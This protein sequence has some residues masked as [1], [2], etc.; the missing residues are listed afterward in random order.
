MTNSVELFAG[1]G[2]LALGLERAGAHHLALYEWDRHSC[3]NL[4]A[5]FGGGSARPEIVCADVRDTDFTAYEGRAD[6]LAGGPPC[7]PFSV[8]GKGMAYNDS[9]DMF[10]EAV[11]ALRE[12]RPKAFVIE[13]VKGL[14]R[15]SFSTYFNYIILQLQHPEVAKKA[16]Q[17]WEEHLAALEKHHTATRR[18]KGL[19]YNV[20]FRL[21]DAADYGVPQRRGR[22]VIVG[23]RSDIDAGWTFPEPTHSEAALLY[24]K[25]VSFTYWDEHNLPHPDAI[26]LSDRQISAVRD[27]CESFLGPKRWRTVR[28]AIGNLPAPAD[29]ECAGVAN[30][31]L[32]HGAREYPG[33]TGSSLDQPSKTIKA[34]A[35]GVPGGENMVRLDDGSLR[36]YTVRESARIQT[37]PDE[38]VFTSPW[39]ESMRQIGNAVPVALAEAIGASVMG[40]LNSNK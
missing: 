11:R 20:T 14:L 15:K 17:T 18:C 38:F 29:A 9:R 10:P 40:K 5:N 19:E 34:G 1:T 39:S 6:L 31:V 27:A 12:I 28:D 2:G 13:N 25:W 4:A 32:R 33:H 26:P 7:Q 30:H 3:A 16:A 37:F 24:A 36:Y 8:G 21:V 22:V 35:H 23:F